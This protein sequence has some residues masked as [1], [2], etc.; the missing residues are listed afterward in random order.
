VVV[1]FMIYVPNITQ[2]FT[3]VITNFVDTVMRNIH[4]GLSGR[5][6]L[7]DVVRLCV[8]VLTIYGLIRILTTRQ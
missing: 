5:G 3:T 6:N 2:F 8:T 4:G 1:I 7:E